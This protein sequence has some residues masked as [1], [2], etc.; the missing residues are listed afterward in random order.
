MDT[1]N[2]EWNGTSKPL[3]N[4]IRAQVKFLL[5]ESLRR[6]PGQ[7][8]AKE[9]L[10]AWQEDWVSLAKEIGIDRFSEAVRRARSYSKFMPSVADI[11]EYIPAPHLND[12]EKWNAELKELIRRKKAGEKFYTLADVFK[13]VARRIKTGEIKPSD[14]GWYEWAARF[15]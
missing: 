1:E 2:Q 5:Q 15:K 13:E 8:Y 3:T 7:Q 4:S 6:Y 12:G 11:R 9:T 14:K 10:Q